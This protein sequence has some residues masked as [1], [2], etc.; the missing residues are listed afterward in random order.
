MQRSRRRCVTVQRNLVSRDAPQRN[1]A[2]WCSADSIA[3]EIRAIDNVNDDDDDEK[4]LVS[5]R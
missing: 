1:T 2:V 5:I 4:P 3:S